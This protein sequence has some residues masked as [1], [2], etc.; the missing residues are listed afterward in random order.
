[1]EYTLATAPLTPRFS[2]LPGRYYSIVTPSPLPEPRLLA[3]NAALAEQLGLAADPAAHPRLAELLVGNLLRHERPL[4]SVYS[5]HQFGQ[6][7]GQLGDGR[8]ILVAELTG[9][10]G[11]IQEIQLKGAGLTPYSRMGDG[12]AVLR[13]SIREYLCSEAMAGLGIPTTRALSLVGSPEPVWRETRETAAVVARVAPTFLRF[14]HFEHFYHRGELE[15]VKELAD[16]TIAHFYPDCASATSPY[17]AL[18]EAVRD[19]TAAMIADWMAVGFCHGVM[20]SDNMSILGLTLDYG[21]FGFLDGFD[22][23]HI[24]NHSDHHGRYAFNQ[25]PQIGLWNLA[26]LAQTLTKL[27]ELD[28]LRAALDGYQTVFEAAYADRLRRKFGLAE[29]LEADWSLFTRLLDLMQAAGT[30]WTIFWRTLSTPAKHSTL[31]DQFV[32]RDAFDAWLADYLARLA[33]DPQ[34]PAEREAAMRMT[35]PRLVLRNHLAEVAIRK[36]GDGDASEIERLQRALS[37][38]FDDDEAFDDLAGP[39]PD[40]AASLSVSCSS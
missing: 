30:D 35:N 28:A 1:M 37:R 22:A 12:R 38:P 3:W 19:R 20:N 8:A 14:G 31:R 18:F 39:A 13:S 26:C 4:A 10:D 21:P 34:T 36:A 23:G 11:G 7:A 33:S 16:W 27:V 25:Q 6:W 17:L 29:W 5:G 2:L 24:C 15:A 40:W 9:V 32:D